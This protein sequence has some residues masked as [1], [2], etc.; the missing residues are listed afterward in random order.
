MPWDMPVGEDGLISRPETLD[1]MRQVLANAAIIVSGAAA[2]GL[3]P[4]CNWMLGL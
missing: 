4:A 2:A 1:W 3:E